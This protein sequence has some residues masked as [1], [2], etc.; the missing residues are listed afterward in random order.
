MKAIKKGNGKATLTTV[1][2][3]TLTASMNGNTLSF[4]RRKR[5]HV[6]SYDCRRQTV[7]RRYSRHRI[8]ERKTP[9]EKIVA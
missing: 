6:E 4:D 7:K 9:G 5:R 1:S 2:G 3:D 8:N